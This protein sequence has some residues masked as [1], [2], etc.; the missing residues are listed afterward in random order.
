MRTRI[1]NKNSEYV[2]ILTGNHYRNGSFSVMWQLLLG[3]LIDRWYSSQ[4]NTIL[5]LIIHSWQ[6][7]IN[8]S[9]ICI[10]KN[11]ISF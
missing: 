8:F 2:D 3:L 7:S 10:D 4:W 9:L 1:L 5:E 6:S 11:T